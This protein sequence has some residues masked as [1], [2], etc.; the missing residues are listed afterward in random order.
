M[1]NSASKDTMMRSDPT[2]DALLR[3]RDGRPV[4]LE[5]VAIDGILRGLAAEIS[6]EQRYRNG[7]AVPIE[8]IYTFPLPV[9][10]VLL[11]LALDSGDATRQALVLERDPA[12]REYEDRVTD[13]DLASL[14]EMLPGGLY[15]LSLGNL[16]PGETVTVRYRYALTLS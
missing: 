1:N 6:V 3:A 12:G 7:R 9:G 4:A 11:D 15:G 14:V 5:S 13:G 8:A 2:A 10:A 16:L